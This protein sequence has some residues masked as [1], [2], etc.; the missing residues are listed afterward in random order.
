M[1]I[2]LSKTDWQQ[3]ETPEGKKYYHNKTSG[4]TTWNLEEVISS[5]WIELPDTNNENRPYYYNPVVSVT[6]WDCPENIDLKKAKLT[7]RQI[8][9]LNNLRTREL[10]K[11][12]QLKKQAYLE[13]KYS[14]KF[15]SWISNKTTLKDCLI[16]LPSIIT[17]TDQQK[18]SLQITSESTNVDIKKSYKRAT[19]ILH[20]DKRTSD[21]SEEQAAL[22]NLVFDA[23]T[24]KYTAFTQSEE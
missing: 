6:T 23:L 15:N 20:P 22:R 24:K 1:P 5:E 14:A 11:E 7:G 18:E 17:L 9:S 19:L 10:E 4:Y 13:E 16:H 8:I 3:Y 2:D 21:L 12:Y